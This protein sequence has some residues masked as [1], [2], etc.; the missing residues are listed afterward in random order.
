MV[1]YIYVASISAACSPVCDNVSGQQT[2]G[3]VRVWMRHEPCWQ[4][5]FSI[6]P[7]LAKIVETCKPALVWL[8]CDVCRVCHVLSVQNKQTFPYFERLASEY[9]P[10]AQSVP[11][12]ECCTGDILPSA[13]LHSTTFPITTDSP[14]LS[15]FAERYSSRRG[16]AFI[17]EGGFPSPTVTLMATKYAIF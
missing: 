14:I 6:S 17:K 12:R 15:T 1:W 8:Q 7:R 10:D 5:A 2:H 11:V 4:D 3:D 16:N 13:A 9:L